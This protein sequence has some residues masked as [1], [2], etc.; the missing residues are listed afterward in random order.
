[1][2][3]NKQLQF[4]YKK[5][6]QN[7]FFLIYGRVIYKNDKDITNTHKIIKIGSRKYHVARIKKGRIYTDYLE[8]VSIIDDN[9]VLVNHVSHQQING[10]MFP[11]KFNSAL[12]KGTPGFKKKI[13]GSILCMTQGISAEINYFHWMFDILP[14]IKLIKKIININDIDYFYFPELK[15]WQKDTLSIFKFSKN[16]FINSKKHRHIEA[17]LIFATSHPWYTKGHM[18]K[19]SKNLPTWDINWVAKTFLKYKKKTYCN[20]KIFIDRSESIFK[21][22]QIINNDE[23]KNNLIKMGFSIHKT[24]KMP[25]FEQI[26]LFNNAKVIV[27]AHGAAFTNLV[28]CKPKT[29][30]IEIIPKSH[31]NKVNK[32][33]SNIKNLNYFRFI[34]KDLKESEK[35][36]GDIVVNIK[37]LKKKLK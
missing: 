33:I 25:F 30:V 29:K 6:V 15:K 28:F 9:N 17:D 8:H 23:V 7:I 21:H 13:K 4:F 22:C 32:K 34:T 5:F 37:A 35:I 14:R 24:G 2:S 3:I 12:V 26:Y 1:M 11:A 27:G 18:V 10:A 31:P 20:K 36:T 16:K 19:E